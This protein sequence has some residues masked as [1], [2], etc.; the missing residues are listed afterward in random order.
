MSTSLYYITI[1]DVE[2]ITFMAMLN[3]LIQ[4]YIFIIKK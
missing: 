2:F 1:L 4:R 3:I